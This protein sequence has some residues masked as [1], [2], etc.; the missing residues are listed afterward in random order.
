MATTGQLRAKAKA[1]GVSPAAI[2]KAT[3]VEDLNALILDAVMNGGSTTKAP[4]KRT[5]AKKTTPA[6]KATTRKPG[7]PAKAK[8]APR[9]V[10][11][12][13][14]RTT[15]TPSRNGN[16]DAGRIELGDVDFSETDGWNAREGSAPAR[17]IAS[18][19]K[20]RG[21]RAKV[22]TALRPN[23]WDFVGRKLQD[24]S[25]RTLA[26]AEDMLRYRISRTAWDFA[27]KTGQHSKATNRAEYGQGT[28]K[29]TPR[30]ARTAPAT[31]KATRTPAKAQ[32]ATQSRTRTT[33][34]R[35]PTRTT[36]RIPVKAGRPVK[37]KTARR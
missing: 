6:R 19:R 28:R 15:T 5:A 30:K 12:K 4:A 26:S 1:L 31:R 20:F 37:K 10:A 35:T 34:K 18:L 2:R 14:T 24:G 11:K 29:N 7:R 27:M 9:P 16:G 33:A 22:F 13:S 17:I 25:K 21:D 32:K 3:T 23:I 8:P 36:K